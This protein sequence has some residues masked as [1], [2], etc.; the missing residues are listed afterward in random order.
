LTFFAPLI[1]FTDSFLFFGGKFI[2][3]VE[4]FSNLAK[5][6][7]AETNRREKEKGGGCRKGERRK[8]EKKK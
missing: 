5:V 8:E 4:S 7:P 6:N 3:D 2:F 1:L